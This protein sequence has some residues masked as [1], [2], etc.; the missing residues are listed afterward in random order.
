MQFEQVH[1]IS[2][3]LPCFASCM[4]LSSVHFAPKVNHAQTLRRLK[5]FARA[6]CCCT[7]LNRQIDS[8]GHTTPRYRM[9]VRC[10]KRVNSCRSALKELHLKE[11]LASIVC[12][13]RSFQHM[14]YVR[15]ILWP[16]RR[17]CTEGPR[18]LAN[19]GTQILLSTSSAPTRP[20]LQSV[21][22]PHAGLQ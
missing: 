5:L 10:A 2:F 21:P 19:K 20:A 14:F 6:A 11:L 9:T 16:C 15:W 4:H 13:A 22:S 12:R 8:G 17:R 3:L 1:I 7:R 18:F